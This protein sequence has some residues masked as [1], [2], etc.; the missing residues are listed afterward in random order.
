MRPPSFQ[1]S[2]DSMTGVAVMSGT[3]ASNPEISSRRFRTH[4]KAL[5]LNDPSIDTTVLELV[6]GILALPRPYCRVRKNVGVPRR[7]QK[8]GCWLPGLPGEGELGQQ[9]VCDCFH[10]KGWQMCSLPRL[11]SLAGK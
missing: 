7:P 1:C 3:V 11:V 5:A 4:R 8:A 9:K 2:I 6:I 10:K